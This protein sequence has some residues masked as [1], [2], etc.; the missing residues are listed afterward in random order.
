MRA[1]RIAFGVALALAALVWF[2]WRSGDQPDRDALAAAREELGIALERR[3]VDVGEVELHVVLAGPLDGPPVVLLHGFPEFW[4]AWRGP[5]AALAR[6]G[7]RVI[8]PDQ[9]GYNRSEKPRG[10]AS[11]RVDRLAADVVG[12]IEGLGYESAYLVGHDWG[13]GVAWQAVL[14]YPQRVRRLAVI[15]TPHPR[16]SEGF[17]SGEDTVNWF[18][19]FIQLQGIAEWSA[20]LGN[21]RMLSGALRSTSREGTFPEPVMDQFRSAWDRENAFRSMAHWYRAGPRPP[22]DG[23]DRVSVPTLVL[24]APDDVYIPGDVSR[25]SEL[26]LDA[27]RLVELEAGSHWVIQ[28]DPEEIG[29]LLVDFFREP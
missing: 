18:R 17:E 21:W 12:L 27:G 14:D 22:R 24:L 7:F 3:F 20:R 10:V 4:Y 11:Y 29:A 13:G 9:R 6:A 15:D 23:D 16:A 25:R 2:G 1:V 5:M 28:E 8:A 19:S 26:F